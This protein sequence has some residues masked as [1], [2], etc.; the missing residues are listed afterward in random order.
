MEL[1]VNITTNRYWAFDRL[2]N[3]KKKKGKTLKPVLI[4]LTKLPWNR[5][6][7]YFENVLAELYVHIL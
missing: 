1:S 4:Y 7:K 6:C 5:T 2:H 3:Q